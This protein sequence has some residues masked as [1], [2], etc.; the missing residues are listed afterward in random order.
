MV[1]KTLLKV[2][3]ITV[4][5]VLLVL[6]LLFLQSGFDVSSNDMKKQDSFYSQFVAAG[7]PIVWFILLPMSV[8]MVYLAVENA[9]VLRKRNPTIAIIM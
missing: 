6:A 2:V 7:G 9:F 3:F 8:F 1:N 4:L 5:L